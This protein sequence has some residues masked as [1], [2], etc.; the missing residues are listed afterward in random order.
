MFDYD[1]I[2]RPWESWYDVHPV[3]AKRGTGGIW[4]TAPPRLGFVVLEN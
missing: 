4:Y 2:P 1:V 3:Q